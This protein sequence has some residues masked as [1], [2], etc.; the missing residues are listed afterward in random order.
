MVC[1][2]VPGTYDPPTYGHSNLIE[3]AS[4]I[5]DR[6]A[7]VIAVNPAKNCTFSAEERL[8]F[9]QEMTAHLPNVSVHL[10]EGLIVDFAREL[11][12]KVMVRGVR[13]LGDF[14]Y[15]FELSILNK[16]LDERIETIFIP[17]DS[18]YFVLRSSSIR[19]LVRFGGDVSN[20]V[21]PAVAQALQERLGTDTH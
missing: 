18:R 14:N 4:R 8:G 17:T 6:I 2:L 3:R 11:D 12:A 21:P 5:F 13:A 9:L 10:W 16:G 1:A 15:E 20:M 7:V 19:E